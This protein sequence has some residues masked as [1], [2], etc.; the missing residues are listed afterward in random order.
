MVLDLNGTVFAS[1]GAG[2][3]TECIPNGCY[4]FNMTDSYGDG[5]NGATYTLTDDA[6]NVLATGDLDTSQNGDG[7]SSGSD[8]IQ[9]WSGILR[10]GMHRCDR[11]QLRPG[12]HVG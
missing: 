7:A 6:G 11:V 2:T 8:L 5:W 3:V 1:G 9:D 4:T 10:L 12:R